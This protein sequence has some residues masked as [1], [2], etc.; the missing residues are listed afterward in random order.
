MPDISPTCCRASPKRTFSGT[1]AATLAAAISPAPPT[2]TMAEAEVA[3]DVA[4][5][6]PGQSSSELI[7]SPKLGNVL[8]FV[9]LIFGPGR[10]M[11]QLNK[12][13]NIA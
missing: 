11:N 6:A 13:P 7:E 10:S 12:K 4:L 9:Q 8:V 3:A 1:A 5:V 2:M